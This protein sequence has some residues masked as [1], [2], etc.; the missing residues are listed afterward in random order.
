MLVVWRQDTGV[1]NVSVGTSLSG[2]DQMCRQDTRRSCLQVDVGS[3]IQFPGEHVL[4]T[5]SFPQ[6]RGIPYDL[7][8]SWP[9]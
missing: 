5:V 7:P 3:L 2:H 8:R 4:E 6:S 1:D 9:P